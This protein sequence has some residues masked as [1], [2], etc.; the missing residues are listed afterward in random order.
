MSVVLTTRL[1]DYWLTVYARTWRGSVITSFLNPLLY[2]VAM[3]V[4]LGSY[5]EGD[6]AELEGA[7]SYLAFVAPG[8][9]AAQTMITVFGE[10]TWPVMSMIKWQRTYVAMVATP[11]RVADVVLGHL[12][13]CLFRVVTVSTVF[14]LVLVPFGVFSSV[15]GALGVLLVQLPLGLAFAGVVFAVTAGALSEAVMNLMFRLG[16]LPMFLFSGAFFPVENLSAPLELLARLT[17]LWHGVS[18]TR[19][20]STGVVDWSLAAINLGYLLAL[21]ALGV[22]LAVRALERRLLV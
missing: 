22:W 1:V 3:G 9:L 4:L 2:V 16:M 18:L 7:T 14:V 19:M 13:F 11:L 12:G 21:C 17:P 15:A 8:L 20:S 6:P 5:I 10:V